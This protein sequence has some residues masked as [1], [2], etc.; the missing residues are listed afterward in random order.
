[1]IT[2]PKGCHDIYGI[3]AKK[4]KYVNDLI[5]SVCEKY[6]YQYIRTPI[7][8]SSELFHRGVGENTDIVTK[9]TYDFVDR[10][11]R[12]M[13]LRPEGTAG[14]M[15][16]YIENKMYGDST[17]PIKLYYNG[18]M[19]RYERPQSGRDR[20]LTQFGVELIG[21]DDPMSDAEVIS[22]A[23]NIYKLVGL[24][25]I[26]VNINSLGDKE[27]RD[28]YRNVLIEY[29]K[30]H[31]D[32]MCDDCKNRL[33]KNPLRILDCKVDKDTDIMKNAP[34][35]TDYLNE[36]SKNRFEQVKKYLQQMDIDYVVDSNVVRGLDYYDH[37]VFEIEA[38]VE[39]FGSQNILGGGGRYNT[40]SSQ[41]GGPDVPGIG[42]AMGLGRLMLAIEKEGIELPIS[43]DIDA[44]VMYV[45][46]TEKEYAATLVQELR[47]S[48]FKVDTEYTGRTL[49]AQF[50]Q[51]DR[52]NSRFLII[53]NDEDLK[54]NQIKI[55]NNK[56]KEEDLVE[57]DYILYYL[58]EKLSEEDTCDC[59][60]DDHNHEC[61]CDDCH[62]H[63]DIEF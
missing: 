23:V 28:N 33:E 36:E 2:K 25:G 39:G 14:I 45:S 22:M 55:K 18:T 19:Y 9:E 12:K 47:M 56:T 58:D 21:S 40:L 10:G 32:S 54:N 43:N 8:E 44:F 29:F 46:D 4:W 61:D 62:C 60:C 49:K 31:I 37:T 53:L 11:D 35:I 52:L 20:E 16:S 38:M 48:G 27:S 30:P 41:L 15:R 7:F 34:K 17:Q 24:K 5:D 57:I 13:T 50:K 26:K 3:E 59:G 6:N 42:F 51:A 1:M 63:D